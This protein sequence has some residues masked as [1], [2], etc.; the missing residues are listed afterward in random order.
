MRSAGAVLRAGEY[1]DLCRRCIVLTS[2]PC[3]DIAQGTDG[4]SRG[5]GSILFSSPQDADR[6]VQMFN[7]WVSCSFSYRLPLTFHAADTTTTDEHSKSISTNS[8]KPPPDP[9]PHPSTCPIPLPTHSPTTRTTSESIR[10]TNYSISIRVGVCRG[11]QIQR[12]SRS[13]MGRKARGRR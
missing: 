1:H 12:S 4:R 3:A 2:L 8:L 6:A 11:G 7:G 9:P 10:T 13:E 5:F